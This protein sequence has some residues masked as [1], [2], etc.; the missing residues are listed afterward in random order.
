[1]QF[2][3]SQADEPFGVLALRLLL[4]LPSI[5]AVLILIPKIHSVYSPY[6][7]FVVRHDRAA[8]V[9]SVVG[10]M[11][12]GAWSYALH[13]RARVAWAIGWIVG[14]AS[15]LTIMVS[16]VRSLLSHTPGPEGWIASSIATI[17]FLAVALRLGKQWKLQEHYFLR[18]GF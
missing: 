5:G 17:A 13:R 10:A 15:F 16:S 8:Q 9:E 2:K 14:G 3:V 6:F 7:N 4:L 1:M 12:C 11:F 18:K